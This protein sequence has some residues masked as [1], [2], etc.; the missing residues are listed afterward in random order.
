MRRP[1]PDFQALFKATPGPCMVLD[2]D[3]TIVTANDAFLAATR[4]RR[5]QIEGRFVFDAF[6]DN[7]DDPQTKAVE[8]STASFNRVLRLKRPDVMAVRRHDVLISPDK[9]GEGRRDQF[10][11]HHWKTVNIPVFDSAGEVEW[12]LYC[13]EDVTEIH[14]LRRRMNVRAHFTPLRR[15]IINQLR[16]LNPL[17]RG[18][19]DR[20]FDLLAEHLTPVLLTADQVLIESLQPVKAVYF[21]LQGLV[22]ISRQMEDGTCVGVA[23][24][25]PIG[26]V[27]ESL[28][29]G[30][31][32]PSTETRVEIAGSA[33]MLDADIFRTLMAENPTLRPGL[34]RGAVPVLLA[35][36]TITA[37]CNAL[38]SMDQRLARLLLS[39]SDWVE[40]PNLQIRQES[41]AMMLGVRRTGISEALTRMSRAG[42]L[43]TG[44]NRIA[45]SD[46]H[47]L[48]LRSCDCYRDLNL[49]FERIGVTATPGHGT[50]ST[51]IQAL[52]DQYFDVIGDSAPSDAH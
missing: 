20:L 26:M 45:I 27:G 5:D 41:I 18:L 29:I 11:E 3:L 34:S 52:F 44:R 1:S 6:P 38:H 46:P 35:L 51:R 50:R 7:P 47:K 24:A 21:L 42:L 31:E 16:D 23:A 12:I 8:I 32:S 14:R 30:S 4:L 2:R 48:E 39:A 28:L 15:D 43:V 10:R 40:S 49:E 19:D 33:L 9:D 22:S 36:S 25:G 13:V 17:L 37:A